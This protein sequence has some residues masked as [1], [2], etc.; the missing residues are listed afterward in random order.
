[1]QIF[2]IK[3]KSRANKVVLDNLEVVFGLGK[4]KSSCQSS[5]CTPENSSCLLL[6][7]RLFMMLFVS[8]LMYSIY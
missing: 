2:I 7:I 3:I 6:L 8:S 5:P 4:S 1:M